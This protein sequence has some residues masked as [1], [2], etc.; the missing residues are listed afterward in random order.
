MDTNRNYNFDSIK[1][2]A[3]KF[4]YTDIDGKVSDFK[5]PLKIDKK[6]T[7]NKLFYF[8]NLARID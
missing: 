5:L 1:T 4:Q 6:F 8:K 3:I 2:L 7:N